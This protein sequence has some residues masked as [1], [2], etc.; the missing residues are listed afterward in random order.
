MRSEP[1]HPTAPFGTILSVWAHPDDETYL[2]AGLMAAARDSGQR[3]MC[4]S[5]T[6]GEHGTDDPATYP[7]SR[8][9]RMRRWEFAAS[10]AV[11]G[12]DEH[13]VGRLPDGDLAAHE[14][15]GTRW[16]AELIE[17]VRPD[18]IVTFGPDGIT[19]H[20]DHIA[21]HRW[22]TS[23]WR[24]M[25]CS[26]RL[27]YATNT[28][29]RLRRF[30]PFY[31]EWGI[32]MSDDRPDGVAPADLALHLSLEGWQ[33]DRKLT[34]LRAMATQTGR[35]MAS[36]DPGLYAAEASEEAFIEAATTGEGR[37]SATAR[38]DGADPLD[39]RLEHI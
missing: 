33:L 5:A 16:V 15:D 30:G 37:G 39:R 7:P 8:L 19:Y 18:T 35:P 24:S 22:V 13:V 26:A 14:G 11:L 6:A 12:V 27:L 38:D 9:D 34:A 20:P 31:E 1:H 25:G 10:M 17:Q 23:A 3:V 28:T 32:Y 29:D 21:V 2:A 4:A 36:I